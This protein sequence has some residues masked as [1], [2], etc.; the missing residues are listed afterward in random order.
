MAEQMMIMFEKY[1]QFT[2]SPIEHVTEDDL[3]MFDRKM[4]VIEKDF[5]RTNEF[6][7]I[8]L[9]ILGKKGG[10]PWCKYSKYN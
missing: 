6:I 1:M 3:Q 9:T 8:S 2:D 5:N 4:S 10:F 7:A